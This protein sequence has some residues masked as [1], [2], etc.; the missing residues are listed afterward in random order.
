MDGAAEKIDWFFTMATKYNLKVLLDVHCLKDSQNGFDNSGKANK[1]VWNNATNFD[2]WDYNAGEW[3]GKWN[4]SGYDSINYENIQWAFDNVE[5]LLQKYGHHNSFYALE[6][7]NEPWW[8]SDMTV[9]KDFYRK[10]RKLIQTQKPELKFV[11]HDAFQFSASVWNDLFDDNDTENVIMDTH[12]YTAWWDR[13][14]DIGKYCDSYQGLAEAYNIKY[15][16]WVGEWSLATDVCAMWLGGFNDNNTPYRFDCEWV[17]CPYS[18][19]PSDLAVDFDRT[20]ATLGP[21]GTPTPQTVQNGNCAK[22]STY[23]GNDDMITLGHCAIYSMNDYVQG[24]F[25]WTYHN[26]LEE[27]WSYKEAY[28]RGWIL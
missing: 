11:F 23:F 7:V 27:K 15:D 2:H 9:L 13:N 1:V 21:Y 18:Y 20:A 24:H 25:L 19:L 28:D 14:N 22:D 17:P 3:M 6:P 26:E 12:F 16:V 10:V 8:N 5:L 4:G